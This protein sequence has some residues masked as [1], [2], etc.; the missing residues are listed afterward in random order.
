[1]QTS[2]QILALVQGKEAYEEQKAGE[3]RWKG[4]NHQ[5]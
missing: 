5:G 1:M 2:A 3:K 4:F